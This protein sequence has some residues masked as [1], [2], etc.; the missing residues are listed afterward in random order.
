MVSDMTGTE[1]RSVPNPRNEAD[2]D[3]NPR[4]VN[5]KL[6]GHGLRPITLEGRLLEEVTDI[7]RKF[8]YRC[9]LNKIPCASFW[10]TSRILQ[11]QLARI[12]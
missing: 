11:A 9:D 6:L 1:I 3:T 10:N 8:S 7:A 4:I 5:D 2:E 12:T